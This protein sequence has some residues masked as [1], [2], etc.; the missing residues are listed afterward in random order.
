MPD[1]TSKRSHHSD[2]IELLIARND[3]REV[4]EGKGDN[5]GWLFLDHSK[6]GHQYG[7]RKPVEA[8]AAESPA[9]GHSPEGVSFTRALCV[10]SSRH[11]ICAVTCTSG[12]RNGRAFRRSR[13]RPCDAASLSRRRRPLR[14]LG[15]KPAGQRRPTRQ[16]LTQWR[17]L[18]LRFGRADLHSSLVVWSRP[19]MGHPCRIIRQDKD[20]PSKAGT[21]QLAREFQHTSANS[22]AATSVAYKAKVTL[23]VGWA[24]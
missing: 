8:R 3:R 1:S 10:E 16:L 12:G 17:E 20:A 14:S 23:E 4:R 15:R 19:L 18:R 5:C 13:H 9:F 11:W 24:T 6:G 2:P 21:K 7:A 22:I